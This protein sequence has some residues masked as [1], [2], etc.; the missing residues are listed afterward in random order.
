M[1]N[2]VSST[3][4]SEMPSSPRLNVMPQAGIHG[5]D[6]P[7]CMAAVPGSNIHQS[8]TEHANS[9]RVPTKATRF[10]EAEGLSNTASAT[11]SGSTRRYFRLNWKGTFSGGRSLS[12][13]IGS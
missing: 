1:V 12:A 7:N 4:N 13:S 10:A 5:W 9:R 8:G 6:T 11:T 3:M 2:V